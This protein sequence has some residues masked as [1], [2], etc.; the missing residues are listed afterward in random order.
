MLENIGLVLALSISYHLTYEFFIHERFLWLMLNKSVYNN[1]IN[2]LIDG[3]EEAD[4][5]FA[6]KEV[7]FCVEIEKRLS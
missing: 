4:L 5:F 2:R 6:L 7:K 1:G 3:K